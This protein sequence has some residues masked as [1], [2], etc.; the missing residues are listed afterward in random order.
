[1][2]IPA[3]NTPFNLSSRKDLHLR[4]SD[5]AEQMDQGLPSPSQS[6]LPTATLYQEQRRAS[7][8][9]PEELDRC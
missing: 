2:S 5:F 8:E 4:H 9:L 1:M 3:L 6:V 7:V